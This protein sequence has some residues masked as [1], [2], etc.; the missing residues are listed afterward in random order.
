MVGRLLL[1]LLSVS[2]AA[3]AE[4]GWIFEQE[5]TLVTVE[6]GGVSAVSHGISGRVRELDNG[7]VRVEV[8]LPLASFEPDRPLGSGE[9][10]DSVIH[11][12]GLARK[13]EKDGTL[14]LKGTVSFRGTSKVVEFPVALVRTGSM[15]FGHAVLTVHLRDFGFSIPGDEADEARVTI[16]AG[17]R[18]EGAL[19]SRESASTLQPGRG[20]DTAQ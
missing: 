10:S 9:D 2:A 18:P 20:S 5:Q 11:F 19:A 16:D 1:A 3:Q 17:L 4:K 15:V 8:R 13:A 14:A 7:G 6:V 12:E